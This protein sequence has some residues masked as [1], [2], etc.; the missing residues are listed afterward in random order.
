MIFT[1]TIEWAHVYRQLHLCNE[2]LGVSAPGEFC[3]VVKTSIS[4]YKMPISCRSNQRASLTVHALHRPSPFQLPAH[5]PITAAAVRKCHRSINLLV[6]LPPW[7][8]A[9]T[10]SDLKTGECLCEQG[11]RTAAIVPT[12]N[13]SG[14]N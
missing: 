4:L 14:L 7:D 10:G 8:R 13:F 3:Q 5:T 2:L 11:P 12:G 1:S 6:P 9:G